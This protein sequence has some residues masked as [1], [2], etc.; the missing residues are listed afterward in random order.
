[1]RQRTKS[2]RALCWLGKSRM[3]LLIGRYVEA[4]MSAT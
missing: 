2:F 1:V 3:S 4:K